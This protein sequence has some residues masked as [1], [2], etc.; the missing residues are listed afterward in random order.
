MQQASI[1]H[2]NFAW[3]VH[4]VLERL[5]VCIQLNGPAL[6][7][8]ERFFGVFRVTETNGIVHSVFDRV[9]VLPSIARQ[10]LWDVLFLARATLRLCYIVN[11]RREY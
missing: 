5:P 1:Q 11:R 8:Q 10:F 7:E 3:I 9:Q 2:P 6:G 4:R